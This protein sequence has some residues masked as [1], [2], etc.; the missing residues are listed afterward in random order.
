M[1]TMKSLLQLSIIYNSLF[2]NWVMFIYITSSFVDENAFLLKDIFRKHIL[3]SFSENL[4]LIIRIDHC[5]TTDVIEKID[6]SGTE[7]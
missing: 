3:K 2:T 4:V 5:I 6:M 7:T 1:S